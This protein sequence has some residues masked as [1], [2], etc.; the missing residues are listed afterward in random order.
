M[1]AAKAAG[2]RCVVTKSVYTANEDFSAADAVFEEIGDE[3]SP[4]FGIEDLAKL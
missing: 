3:E 2:M 1:T 4:K